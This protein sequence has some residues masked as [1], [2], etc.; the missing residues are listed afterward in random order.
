[1]NFD[2]RPPI[3]LETAEQE[4][5]AE[6]DGGCYDG[7]G[8]DRYAIYRGK[9]WHLVHYFSTGCDY[10]NRVDSS[11]NHLGHWSSLE[12]L[13]QYLRSQTADGTFPWWCSALLQQLRA[14]ADEA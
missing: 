5:C 12:K 14:P 11:C 10:N 1:M 8:A 4:A 3:N 2:N 7:I 6:R 9:K 13:A